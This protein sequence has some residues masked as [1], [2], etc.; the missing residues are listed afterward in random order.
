MD[1]RMLGGACSSHIELRMPARIAAI[2]LARSRFHLGILLAGMPPPPQNGSA[3]PPPPLYPPPPPPPSPLVERE[4][5]AERR[6]GSSAR[7][8][9]SPGVW[10]ARHRSLVTPNWLRREEEAERRGGDEG[11][12]PDP[13]PSLSRCDWEFHVWRCCELIVTC[14]VAAC[15]RAC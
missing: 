10:E 7:E 13:G 9:P 11:G 6:A 2:R 3:S 15:A 1:G 12:N 4:V 5:A 14:G 8:E